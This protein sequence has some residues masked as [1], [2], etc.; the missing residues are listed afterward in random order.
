MPPQEGENLG[1]LEKARERLYSREQEPE[2]ED[3]SLASAKRTLPHG[4][5]D[6]PLAPRRKPLHPHVKMA[7]YFFIGA[8]L[9]FLLAL[10][11]A[12]YFFYLGGN[13]VSVNNVQ[14]DIQGPTS[15]AGGDTVPLS[16]AVTNKNSVAISNATIDI[17]FPPGTRNADNLYVD[18]P[19]YT[20]NL[21]T[22]DSGQT[23]TRSLK[24]VLFGS[25]GNTFNLPV[26]LSYGTEGS[27]ATFEKKS[28]YG[29]SISSTPLSVSVDSLTETVSGQPMTINLT[30]RNNATTAIHDV[31][32]SGQ[33]PFG[34]Q[35]TDSSVP[36]TGSSFLLGTLAPGAV[37]QI[38]L[39]GVLTGQDGDQRVFHFSVGT[40][41]NATDPTIAVTY[42]TQES[43]VSIALPFI[44]T[45]LSVNGNSSDNVVV[46]PGSSQSVSLSYLNTLA[47][48]ISNAQ[49]SVAISGSA[50]DYGSITSSD[51]FYDSANHTIVFS[52]DT[53]PALS[54][55]APGAS[56]IGSFSF[57]TLPAGSVSYDP[58]ITFT[59]SV[60]GTRIGQTNVPEQVTASAKKT[61]KVQ[62]AVAL[63]ARS[64]HRSG[65]FTNTGPIPP[66][67]NTPTTY[68]IEWNA[69]NTGSAVA[70]GTVTATIPST[71][72]TYLGNTSG[73]GTISYD[74]I[75][76]TVTWN[77]G[78]LPQGSTATADFQVSVTPSITQ[79]GS[80][81]NLTSDASFS[82]YDRYAGVQVSAS[83]PA[84]STQ[85]LTDPGYTPQDAIVK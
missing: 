19:R 7:G 13:A 82:G 49:V 81:P 17:A 14:V 52:S 18:Y 48:S 39:T 46:A 16:I 59:I 38:K 27:N 85:T 75:T 40:A 41:K 15:I 4:W 47:T 61:V 71:Y 54:S 58:S 76:H 5:G 45:K 80:A 55:L 8:F 53:D 74:N 24:V 78:D 57:K 26:T 73:T 72:V 64:L 21:G 62:T 9:F 33:F 29:I 23:A 32:L 70:G 10:A 2:H 31:V 20:E 68:T 22:I 69:K 84:V 63:S 6:E 12:G 43:T 28:S 66:A 77:V 50:V 56:G 67:A 34:F 35:P 36:L 65:P 51:G 44:Q 79:K 25:A 60:S 37:K 30:V 11:A 1:S 83:A 3:E 42:M